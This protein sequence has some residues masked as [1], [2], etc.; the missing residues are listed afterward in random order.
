VTIDVVVLVRR[1]PSIEAL[2]RALLAA[3]PQLRVGA[4][5]GGVTL[6]L[7]DESRALVANVEVPTHVRVPG[8]ATRLLDM[9]DPPEPPYWWIEL[10]CPSL[11]PNATEE[12]L[13]LAGSL[14]E[15]LDGV[16]WQA[17]APRLTQ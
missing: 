11:R 5:G 9:A 7:F 3:G 2:V 15:Q 8:E 10:R 14:A 6:Q 17:P 13:R 1:E 4:V 16:V 12:A